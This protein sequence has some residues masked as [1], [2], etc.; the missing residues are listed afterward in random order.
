M[1]AKTPFILNGKLFQVSEEGSDGKIKAKCCLCPAS[2]PPLSESKKATS[3]FLLHLKR[4]HPAEVTKFEKSKKAREDSQETPKNT[5]KTLLQFCNSKKVTQDAASKAIVNLIVKCGLPLSLVEAEPFEH[6]IGTLSSG[7]CK[8]I[9]RK[10]LSAKIDKQFEA[11]MT[12]I[13][14]VLSSKDN[15]CTTADIWS[16]RKRSFLGMTVHVVDPDTLLRESFAIACE[17][18]SGTHSFDAITEKNQEVHDRFGLDYKKI[19]H[20]I[21]DNASTFAKAFREFGFKEQSENDDQENS[22]EEVNFESIND[23]VTFNGENDEELIA[24]PSQERC[25]AHTLSSI[26][27]MDIKKISYPALHKKFLCHHLQKPPQFGINAIF[28]SRLKSFSKFASE[29]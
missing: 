8:S 17:R 22:E 18:F 12:S 5:Q 20:T 24:L 11:V 3:N 2:K 21:T 23:I 27:T 7:T 29:T 15:A 16:Q 1:T 13:K 6:L 9:N 14:N 28:L 25:F 4:K 26:A 19:T 10:S